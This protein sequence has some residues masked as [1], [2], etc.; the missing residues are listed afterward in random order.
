MLGVSGERY[1]EPTRVDDYLDY[2]YGGWQTP[3]QD[4][5]YLEDDD[6]IRHRR[7]T[8]VGRELCAVRP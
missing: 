2:R 4:W 7:P 5:R 6:A 1:R 8:E 3:V